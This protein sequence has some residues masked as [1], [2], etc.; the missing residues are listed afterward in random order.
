M[1]CPHAGDAS[2]RSS[3]LALWQ[4]Q[5]AINSVQWGLYWRFTAT[6]AKFPP[7]TALVSYYA[8]IASKFLI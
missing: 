2:L 8:V 6:F 5:V 7:D 3:A 1:R 4:R